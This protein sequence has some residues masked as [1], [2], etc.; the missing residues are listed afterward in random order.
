MSDGPFTYTS[1]APTAQP[2]LAPLNPNNGPETGGTAITITGTQF[3]PGADG[4]R[5]RR[6]R[7]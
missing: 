3:A 2:T 4:H 5:Q 7:D 1:V 6:V